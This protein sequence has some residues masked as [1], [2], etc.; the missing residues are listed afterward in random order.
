MIMETAFMDI[1]PGQEQAFEAAFAEAK[2]VVAQ[3]KGFNVIHLH[4]GVERPSTYLV[5]IGWDTVEDHM[6]GFRESELFTQWRA[7]LGP[8]F[9][10]PPAVEHWDLFED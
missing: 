8:H 3:A 1:V 5:A 10:N 4:R 7:L 2:K 6:V 9:A